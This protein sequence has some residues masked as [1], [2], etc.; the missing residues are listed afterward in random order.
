MEDKKVFIKVDPK[1]EL[2]IKSD[3]YM[4]SHGFKHFL[5]ETSQWQKD[6][7]YID[8]KPDY[9]LKEISL[10]ELIENKW[11]EYRSITNNEDAWSFKEWLKDNSQSKGIV[12]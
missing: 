3:Q 10:T 8:N 11:N 2:P 4:T 12:L 6:Y 9:W 5:F 1:E 7:S